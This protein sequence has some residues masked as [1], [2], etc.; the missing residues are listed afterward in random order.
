MDS[1]KFTNFKKIAN[2]F[3][4]RVFSSLKKTNIFDSINKKLAR[5]Q[6]AKPTQPVQIKEKIDAAVNWGKKKVENWGVWLK[7]KAPKSV[8]NEEIYSFKKL[9]NEIEQKETKPKIKQCEIE[10]I[11]EISNKK[12]KT[13]FDKFRVEPNQSTEISVVKILME[14]ANKVINKRGL[15]DG[16]KIRW[17]I[18]HPS[19]NKPISSKLITIKGKL[20]SEITNKLSGFVEYKQ[21]PLSEVKFEIQSTKI[22]RGAG[23]LIVTNSN[24]KRK[25]SVITIK[26]DDSIC[27]ARAIVTAVA[28]INKSKWTQTQLKDGFNRSRKLQKDMA[29]KLHEEAGVEINEF[30]STLEDVKTFANHLKIQ[31]NIVD[32]EHFNDLIFS[33]ENEHNSQ[34]IYL[35]KNGNHFDVITSM[36]GFLCKSYYCHTCKKPY[37]KRDCHKC[38]AKCIACFKYFPTGNK[39]DGKVIE[40]GD[41]NRCFFGKKCFEEHKR[42]RKIKDGAESDIVCEKVCK[43]LKCGRIVTGG[44]EKHVCGHSECSNCGEYCD[45]NEHRCFMVNKNCKGGNCVGCVD[46]KKCYS[47]K[48][49]TDKYIFYDFETNQE[50][51]VHVVNWVDCE[52]FHGN[53]N[54]FETIDEFC[55]FVFKEKNKGFTF[56]AHNAKGYDAQFIRNW[57]IENGMKPYCIYNGTKIMSMEVSGRRF[58]DSLNFVAAPL[59]SFP[60][61]F[62]LTELK[63]GYFPHYFNKKHNQNYVGPIPSKK[64]F[65]FDRMSS[66]GRKAFVE[67]HQARVDENYVFDFKK[68]LREYCR[69]DVDILR[70]S[71]LK[72]RN[73]FIELENIDP[74]LYTTIASVCMTVYRCNYM[75][76]DQIGVVKDSSRGE[77]FSKISIAWLDWI[78]EREGVNI[79]HALN[80]GEKNLT[81]IGKVD[82][83][84]EETKTVYEFQGCFWHGCEKCFS[85]DTINTKNQ[86]DMLT[87][88]KRTQAKNEKIRDCGWKLVE[89]YEC[90]LKENKDFLTWDFKTWD[91]ECIEPLNPRDAFF[92]GR[93]N[94]TK[95][96]YDFK[97]GEKGKYV[98]F[99]SLYPTVQ[100][101]KDYP[102][103]HPEKIFL[104]DEYDSNWFGFVK[105]KVLPPRGLY[106]P[107]LPLKMTCRNAEKLLFPLCKKCAVLKSQKKCLHSDEERMFVGTWCTNELNV[108]VE[109]GYE[110]QKIYEVWNFK[111]RSNELFKG[112]VKKFM[113]IKMESSELKTGEGC[114][115]KSVDEYRKVV[116]SKLGIELG[117]IKFN[118]GMRAISKLCLN[119]LWGKFGQ[120]NNMKK[121]V[122]VVEPHEFYKILLDEKIEDLNIHFI[123]EEMVEMNYNLKDHFV[124]NSNNTN[125]FIAAFTTSHARMM[126]YGV[127]DKLGKNVLGFDTDSCWYIEKENGPT[128]KTGDNLGDLTYELGGHYIEKWCG[129]GPKSYS[130]CTSNGKTVCKV[131]GFTLNYENSQYINQQT[132]R[133]IIEGQ[134]NRITT[135]NEQMITRDSKTKEV[136]NRYQEKDFT[137]CYDKRAVVKTESGIETFPYGY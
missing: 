44:L 57:C 40:C 127:L 89:Q 122:Y 77:K 117:E 124:D 13:F 88:R 2:N 74:L 86:M 26:N 81:D 99:V 134:K 34:M 41:C 83:F 69:S 68:E 64:H 104:P 129:T 30:G 54:T 107:V 135:V 118:P 73:D 72:F 131:K 101:Y 12:F 51:G 132:M 92:G 58:I 18:S 60:K 47:C 79:K 103:G 84:C 85:S 14:M 15:K 109:K 31:I 20:D 39:C 50:T 27:L 70:R 53:K 106:H 56:I 113:K 67:W 29:E 121:S 46:E 97:E 95:L 137:M 32:G 1:K 126:L 78:S 63:K 45:M 36:T 42:E 133:Q 125:I 128:I 98:D 37:K 33:T 114:T 91:R 10:N 8:V 25:K 52:D 115:Y 59:A 110:I 111:N 123:N 5:E 119:S 3:G 120:R 11:G 9:M 4:T 61:T 16:D 136:K 7:N 43:C 55:Q 108:A 96:T 100:F 49:R 22:P 93:T 28:N 21:V 112:Y 90:G 24:M 75:P 71:M 94:V 35:H 6:P 105:C 102:V 130:Y 82:G 17:I 76:S 48:T 66:Y 80:G 62:G 23:R 116:K 65:G 87:L 19:W 38:P